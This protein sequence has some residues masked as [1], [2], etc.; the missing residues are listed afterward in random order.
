MLIIILII[1]LFTKSVQWHWTLLVN[2]AFW[3]L[4]EIGPRCISALSLFP[5]AFCCWLDHFCHIDKSQLLGSG[6]WGW[7]DNYCSYKKLRPTPNCRPAFTLSNARK[8]KKCK[9]VLSDTLVKWLNQRTCSHKDVGS[10]PARLTA[11]FTMTRI[12]IVV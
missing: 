1:Y 5:T 9:L 11:D 4:Y 7:Q 10:I 8:R 2:S 12:S 6:G 3:Q